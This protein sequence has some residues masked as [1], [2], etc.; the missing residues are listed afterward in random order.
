MGQ[1]VNN[2][3]SIVCKE[4][5]PSSQIMLKKLRNHFSHQDYPLIKAAT[6]PTQAR[7]LAQT[8]QSRLYGPFICLR[9]SNPS[10]HFRGDVEY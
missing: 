8:T 3:N 6:P 2:S 5:W 10:V 4:T 9:K 1:C 7:R